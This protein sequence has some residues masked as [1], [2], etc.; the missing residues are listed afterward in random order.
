MTGYSIGPA[1][2]IEDSFYVRRID[3]WE[4]VHADLHNRA[5]A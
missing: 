4:E 5:E 3:E 1:T 2:P